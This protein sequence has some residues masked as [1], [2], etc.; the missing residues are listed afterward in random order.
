MDN[1]SFEA[2]C[3]DPQLLN[4]PISRA[5][6][7]AYNAADRIPP[8]DDEERAIWRAISGQEVFEPRDVHQLVLVK[9]RRA[10]GTK[11][12]CKRI[13]WRIHTAGYERFVS[14]GERLHAI[15]TAQDKDT[16]REIKSYFEG[17][18]TNSDVLAAEVLDIFRDRILLRNGFVISVKTCSFRAPRGIAVPLALLD[19]IGIWRTEGSNIDREVLRAI[20]PAM[21]QFPGRELILAG[22]PWV[23]EG[24]LKEASTQPLARSDR[25][26]L[27]CPTALMIRGQSNASAIE[28]ELETERAS[29]PENFRRE[30]ECQWLADRDAYLPEA[31][32][33]AANTG[34]R[35]QPPTPGA[36]H[37]IVADASSLVGRD[38][39]AV[40]GGH[41]S[42]EVA[43]VDFLRAWSQRPVPLVCD[44][45]A[46]LA[47]AYGCK[48]I[49]DQYGFAFLR[50]LMATR[51]VQMEQLPFSSRSKPE[52][53]LDLK[54]ALSQG[55]LELLD[56]AESLRELRML[57]ATRLSGGGYRIS[58]PRGR[59]DDLACVIAMFA[60]KAKCPQKRE[61]QL[62]VIR[63]PIA[64]RG[65]VGGPDRGWRKL[66][67]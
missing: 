2:F 16:A 32:I 57:E 52:I 40:L 33:A 51:G 38:K 24:L 12:A 39:F 25:F 35:E 46:S 47:K 14:K 13:C 58:A 11:T 26:V 22:T 62:K 29:D 15:I 45:M 50:E 9:G 53:F 64:N 23:G 42:G 48:V 5:W 8:R 30:F 55:K 17:F 27:T 60:H 28:A 41:V 65:D 18:Y 59:N 31:D 56:H 61:P 3:S 10:G 36:K 34:R 63:I 43:V 7:V 20:T 4:E 66:G 67:G 6:A 37:I 49:A 54:L 19:E 21:V 44:E 1:V